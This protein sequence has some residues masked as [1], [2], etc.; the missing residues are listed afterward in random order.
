M[1]GTTHIV[2]SAIVCGLDNLAVVKAV[3]CTKKKQKKNETT[4]IFVTKLQQR[5]SHAV[6][7]AHTK[8]GANEISDCCMHPDVMGPEAD[9]MVSPNKIFA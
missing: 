8:N 3:L 5:L 7:D 6:H 2:M 1:G 9:N 4:R